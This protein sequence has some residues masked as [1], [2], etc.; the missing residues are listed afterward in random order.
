M[1]TIYVS[2]PEIISNLGVTATKGI[3]LPGV[4]IGSSNEKHGRSSPRLQETIWFFY[5]Y[6]LLLNK[7]VGLVLISYSCV[8]TTP[9]SGLKQNQSAGDGAPQQGSFCYVRGAGERQWLGPWLL[10]RVLHSGLR[11]REQMELNL[12]MYPCIDLLIS[13]VSLRGLP[14]WASE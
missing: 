6:A 5:K 4:W 1:R 2:E 11:R 7:S 14:K 8:Q 10:W 9:N 12:F 13:P 3:V